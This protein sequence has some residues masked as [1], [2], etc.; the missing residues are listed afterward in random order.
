MSWG[1][2]DRCRVFRRLGCC[3]AVQSSHSADA[4]HLSASVA[5]TIP[6]SESEGR[7]AAGADK[8]DRSALR[9]HSSAL[10]GGGRRQ[11]C[12]TP[13]RGKKPSERRRNDNDGKKEVV[14]EI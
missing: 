7:A 13:A 10:A 9:T 3:E 11:D 8:E 12:R 5:L 4:P 6:N 1:R 2:G 14:G